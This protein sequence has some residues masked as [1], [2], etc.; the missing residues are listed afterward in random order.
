[1]RGLYKKVAICK[2]SSMS[3]PF[4]FR[5]IALAPRPWLTREDGECAFPIAGD[6]MRLRCCCNPCGPGPYCEPHAAALRGPPA[7][8]VEDLEREIL[9]W[10]ERPR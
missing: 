6:G 1:M 4:N 9:Q 3:R 8:P 2:Y 7:P 10:L 5:T